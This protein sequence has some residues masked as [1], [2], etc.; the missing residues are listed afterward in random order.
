M[1][2]TE[3]ERAMS[4]RH[5]IIDNDDDDTDL[6]QDNIT[7][8]GG[9]L[10]T[11][12]GR[13]TSTGPTTTTTR[14]AT[15]SI[16][17]PITSNVTTNTSLTSNTNMA[18]PGNTDNTNNGHTLNNANNM[19]TPNETRQMR[20]NETMTQRQTEAITTTT[21]TI[22]GATTI[23]T[24]QTTT[25]QNDGEDLAA[26]IKSPNIDIDNMENELIPKH[27]TKNICRNNKIAPNNKKRTHQT[28]RENNNTSSECSPPSKKRKLNE[29]ERQRAATA[30][31]FN[32]MA[33]NKNNKE[34]TT[35]TSSTAQ[36]PIPTPMTTQTTEEQ[37]QPIRMPPQKKTESSKNGEDEH[38]NDSINNTTTYANTQIT[39]TP[40]T[41]SQTQQ[42]DK[43]PLQGTIIMKDDNGHSVELIQT[44]AINNEGYIHVP[45][46][47]V[48]P[49]SNEIP[50]SIAILD[51]N[52]KVLQ[53]AAIMVTPT[54]EHHVPQILSD[55]NT[56]NAKD[57][58]E[59]NKQYQA[60]IHQLKAD[61]DDIK[62]RK[63]NKA[64]CAKQT[65]KQKDDTIFN[66]RRDKS[67]LIQENNNYK[68]TNKQQQEIIVAL[69]NEATTFQK[70]RENQTKIK[71]KHEEEVQKLKETI[72][73]QQQKINAHPNKVE[74]IKIL[75]REQE[76][77]T[78]QLKVAN[79]QLITKNTEIHQQLIDKHN[80]CTTTKNELFKIEGEL[81]EKV[82]MI[83]DYSNKLDA[84]EIKL[85][86]EKLKC[87]EFE[88]EK[89]DQECLMYKLHQFRD[90]ND[91]NLTMIKQE[92]IMEN[93]AEMDSIIDS[94]SIATDTSTSHTTTTRTDNT[95]NTNL[96]PTRTPSFNLLIDPHKTPIHKLRPQNI[97]QTHD[98]T[99]TIKDWGPTESEL[100]I[101]DLTK[102]FSNKSAPGYTMLLQACNPITTLTATA[103]IAV[104]IGNFPH[105]RCKNENL[106]PT[107]NAKIA[108]SNELDELTMYQANAAGMDYNL[109]E[110]I[111]AVGPKPKEGGRMSKPIGLS[112]TI[113]PEPIIMITTP[114]GTCYN[115]I[116]PNGDIF[117][118]NPQN[119]QQ[120]VAILNHPRCKVE[121]INSPDLTE[122]GRTCAILLI[123]TFRPQCEYEPNAL[124]EHVN[125]MA[126]KQMFQSDSA[127]TTNTTS[128]SSDVLDN[129]VANIQST[130]RSPN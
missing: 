36:Q 1:M 51:Q 104:V 103:D 67:K 105:T 48:S 88:N 124:A 34:Q 10:T 112:T 26:L 117:T 79:Q 55:G 35:N 129:F 27:N 23:T 3:Q 31:F 127:S 40:Q 77:K 69:K 2:Q 81:M 61:Y 21:T 82:T 38:K 72:K 25:T 111:W 47:K 113:G 64:Q 37:Q 68:S 44:P 20:Q 126:R 86:T 65:F 121:M 56:Y 4:A 95:D 11:T 12:P 70:S 85:K 122:G 9:P 99:G 60:E 125:S 120:H 18:T 15:T 130:Q 97:M 28:M 57:L 106:G 6:Q 52:N 71:M 83:E 78:N 59:Q 115:I 5:P 39:N 102:V 116:Y 123:S 45:I 13:P 118:M 62:T 89:K 30:H 92:D 75:L 24:P 66:L 94:P 108:Q 17:D 14:P 41:T 100:A 98:G 46:I 84:M 49:I 87:Q 50:T 33:P 63:E 42:N 19:T 8:A 119:N 114:N 91:N 74:N 16:I 80:E 101:G 109:T 22:Q 54:N 73:I 96:A 53:A 93:Q 76:A 128:T 43:I 7:T 110:L 90:E 29:E 32:D 107:G 58:I